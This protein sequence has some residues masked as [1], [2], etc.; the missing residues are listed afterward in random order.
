MLCDYF[1]I[2]SSKSSVIVPAFEIILIFWRF[3]YI[4]EILDSLFSIDKAK[5][6]LKFCF[7]MHTYGLKDFRQHNNSFYRRIK[8][9]EMTLRNFFFRF[10]QV[11]L[12]LI[13]YK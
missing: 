4:L 1:P 6:Y 13:F 2:S 12:K 3:S 11:S 7:D 5:F 8:S 10:I 9:R